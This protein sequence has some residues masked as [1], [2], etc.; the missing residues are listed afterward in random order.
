[1]YAFQWCPSATLTRGLATMTV[2]TIADGALTYGISRPLFT[3]KPYPKFSF[4]VSSLAFLL[5]FRF[6]VKHTLSQ[7]QHGVSRVVGDREGASFLAAFDT[8]PDQGRRGATRTLNAVSGPSSGWVTAL[9]SAPSTRLKERRSKS[10][11]KSQK[12]YAAYVRDVLSHA[13]FFRSKR[14]LH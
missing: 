11:R 6:A 10:N 7:V 1:M 4:L 14:R 13:C 5:S 8:S 9:P 12:R 3:K 2:P